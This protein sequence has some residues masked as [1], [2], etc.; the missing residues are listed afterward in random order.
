VKGARILHSRVFFVAAF[1]LCLFA[2]AKVEGQVDYDQSQSQEIYLSFSYNGL[3]NTVITALYQGD[4]VYIPIGTLLK[5]LKVDVAISRRDSTIKGFYINPVNHYEVN[6]RKGLAVIGKKEIRFDSSKAIVGQLDFYVLPSVISKIFNLNFTVDFNSLALSLTTEEELPIVTDYQREARRSYLLTSPQSSLLQAPLV[7]P[8]HRSLLNGGVVDYSLT[9]FTD[10]GQ[11]TYNYTL[12]GGG[13]LLGGEVEGS[14]FGNVSGQSSGLYSSNLSWKYV[15]DSTGYISSAGIGNLYSNGLTQNGFR[16]VQISNEPVALR[17]L[18]STYPIDTK[19]NPNW[20]VELYLNGQLVGYTKADAS[21]N[22]HFTI[23]LV[24]G[25]SFVQLKYYGPSG[26]VIESDRRLQ[27]PFTFLPAGQI[28]YTIGGGKLNNT[29]QNYVSGDA[30]MGI[31][32]W[33]TEKIG[34]DYVDNPLFSRPLIYNSLSLRMGTEYMLS[35]DAAPSAYYRSTFNALYSSQASFDVAYTRYQ[36]NLLYNPSS[37][38]QDGQADIFLPLPFSYGSFN[39]RGS[40][41]FQEYV[42]GQKTYSYSAFLNSSL[43]QFNTS[44]GYQTSILDYSGSFIR[45]YGITA[46]VLYSLMFPQGTL[47]FLNGSLLN[48]SARYGVLKNS[49]DDIRFEIS[50]NIQQFVRIAFAVERDFVNKF[51]MFN[52]QIVADLPF[53]RSTSNAQMQNGKTWF[54]E[55]VAGSVGFD[56]KYDRFLFNNLGWVGHSGT[57]MRMYVDNNNDGRFD[58]GDEVIRDGTVT[59]RQAVSSQ[60]SSD[61]I[62]REWNLLPYTQYSADI[63]LSSIK[64]PLLIPKMKSFSFVTDPNSYKPIDIPFFAGG[65]VDGTVLKIEGESTSAVPG[66][67]LEIRGI[68]SDIRKTI[69]VFSDGT[70]YY[71]GLPPGKY[72]ASVD[73]SQLSV[74]DVYADPAIL[75]FEVKPTKN[76]DYVEGLKI[77][78]RDRKPRPPTTGSLIEKPWK[79]VVSPRLGTMPGTQQLEQHIANDRFAGPSISPVY[80]I[81]GEKFL[82]D[83][84][85]TT[86]GERDQSSNE[87][88]KS[89]VSLS[90][91]VAKKEHAAERFPALM[92]NV[93]YQSDFSICKS[94]DIPKYCYAI[95]LAEFHSSEVAS[96]FC[97]MTFK[98]IGIKPEVRL[99]KVGRLFSVVLAPFKNEEDAVMTTMALK[100]IPLF[101]NSFT[102]VLYQSEIPKVIT[103]SIDNFPTSKSANDF[104]QMVRK[105]TGLLP[106]VDSD[107]NEMTFRV[108]TQFVTQKKDQLLFW[109]NSIHSTWD[110]RGA[111]IATIP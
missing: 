9:G 38:L 62:M 79:N 6:F 14:V 37:K 1:L 23:P 36:S 2:A 74:L 54:T 69:S 80:K 104:C 70:F 48:A 40:A 19:T 43:G 29:D 7:Y 71:M 10:G 34:M 27:I 22:A 97:E 77:L 66:L 15:F 11:T 65:I 3:V 63:D 25:T 111:D 42:G 57:S 56:S 106:V 58:K 45:S 105:R 52:L 64:N 41:I 75:T 39:T 93:K 84:S 55:N 107:K 83:L 99:D 110:Y 8:R 109:I 89:Q 49:P 28:T 5:Q 21:G 95:Q 13:E 81:P 59:L 102:F 30:V 18:F 87:K 53:I 108:S 100:E 50:K 26:E 46:N 88:S 76:G 85:R 44:I 68:D 4:S 96:Q 78:L 12:T 31:T 90:D 61:G 67:T 33:M 20:G 17:T 82:A 51:S 72:E 35:L 91:T 16:G 47:D 103:I 94:D 98:Q 92:S 32:D 101:S 86:K 60:L 24:Y 73:S